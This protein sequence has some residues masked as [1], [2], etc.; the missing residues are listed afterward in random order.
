MSGKQTILGR[1]LQLARADVNALVDQAE[2]PQKLLDQLIRDYSNSIREAEQAVAAT[3]GNLRLME[4]DHKE[5]TVAADE[6]GARALAASRKA[7]ELRA[8][9]G[10]AAQA[11]TFDNLA[12]KALERQITAESEA[13]AAEPLIAAQTAVVEKLTRNL[14]AMR[15]KLVG[16]DSRRD[17]LVARAGAAEARNRMLDAVA[18]MDVT[19]PVADLG[20]FEAK[21]RRE[22][23]RAA[24][25]AELADSSLDGQFEQL[26][27]LGKRA[28]VD[29]RLA[30]LKDGAPPV[31]GGRAAA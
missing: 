6:W 4:A 30:R 24:G 2:D 23:A 12:R 19:D 7:D 25:R 22:E 18:G 21:I 10:G 29:A 16:L 28:E 8:G 31:G 14:D 20:R 17:R 26:D 15:E 9:G 11:E 13:A 3:I 5:D 1:T 27:D